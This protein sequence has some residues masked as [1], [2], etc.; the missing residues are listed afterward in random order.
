MKRG[1]G[2]SLLNNTMNDSRD[3]KFDKLSVRIFDTSEAMGNGAADSIAK[4]IRRIATEKGFVRMMFAAAPSQDTTLRA[5]TGMSDI[6]WDKVVAFHMDEYVGISE[7]CPQSFRNYLYKHVF[8][9]IGCSSVH[10]IEGDAPDTALEVERYERLLRE[11]P[12]DIVVLGIG[13]NG[14]IAFNDPPEADFDDFR[15]VRIV[16]LSEKSRIQQ[17]HDGCFEELCEVPR[18]AITV[19]IPAFRSAK[20]LHCVVPNSRKARAVKQALIGPVDASCPA[21]I[22]RTH[23]DATL[24][25][26]SGSFSLMESSS[27]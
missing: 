24:F 17:V 18:D 1:G 13:E 15:Y 6:P 19:T 22:L 26:D 9:L 8:S 27:T 14:H 16:K 3:L 20:I 25:L 4:D 7:T 2:L 11:A 23:S 21:S 12:L 5:L 10:Y